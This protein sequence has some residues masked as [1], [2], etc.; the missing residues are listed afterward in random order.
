MSDL[1]FLVPLSSWERV[2]AGQGDEDWNWSTL[3]GQRF[4]QDEA[5]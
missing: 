4:E 1:F 2:M 5:L 3:D